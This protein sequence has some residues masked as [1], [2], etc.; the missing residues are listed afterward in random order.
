M[1]TKNLYVEPEFQGGTLLAWSEASGISVDRV[2]QTL[3]VPR[4]TVHSHDLPGVGLIWSREDV[5]APGGPA[6]GRG[7]TLR[8]EC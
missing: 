2:L 7:D 4:L 8:G 5:G 6:A 3:S 1:E